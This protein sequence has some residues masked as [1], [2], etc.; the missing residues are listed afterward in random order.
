MASRARI[1]S[2]I[3]QMPQAGELASIRT[4]AD[5]A[6]DW[7]R[8]TLVV[9]ALF[10]L[11]ASATLGLAIIGLYATL[12]HAVAQ[13][14]LEFGIRAAIGARPVDI[15]TLTLREGAQLIA[16]GIV[17]GLALAAAVSRV[18]SGL[19]W[20]VSTVDPMTYA[21]TTVIIATVALLSVIVPCARATRL[22]PLSAI[23]QI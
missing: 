9:D 1:P 19:V 20:G 3:E 16:I 6:N 13:R 18:L 17:L 12:S 21:V 4:L 22:D 10:G 7:R 2:V 15:F 11:I 23:R 14:T 5:E 8:S